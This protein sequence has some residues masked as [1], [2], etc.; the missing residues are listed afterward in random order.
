MES[1][2]L[3]TE[4]LLKYNRVEMEL[5][6]G[7]LIA[8]FS[9]LRLTALNIEGQAI[10]LIDEKHKLDLKDWNCTKSE[11]VAEKEVGDKN[12][13]TEIGK[14]NCFCCQLAV[15]AV[16][17]IGYGWSLWAK[18]QVVKMLWRQAVEY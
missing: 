8:S 9:L 10:N 4:V 6:K 17:S 11:T 7:D 18:P 1:K 16:P 12:L 14:E 15:Y 5:V 2:K 13:S 3:V